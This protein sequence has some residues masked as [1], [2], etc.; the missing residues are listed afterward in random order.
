FGSAPQWVGW[1]LVV[2]AL[3]IAAAL[4]IWLRG[5]TER[6]L[7]AGLGLVVGGAVG[8][9]VDRV[10]FGAVVDFLDLHWGDFHWPAFNVADSAITVGVVLLI[11]DALKTRP[12]SP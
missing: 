3:A 7:A 8:N 5:V 6:L 2:F 10:R 9:V 12:G 1:A 4:S 11:L